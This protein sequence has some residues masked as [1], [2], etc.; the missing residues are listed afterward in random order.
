MEGFDVYEDAK[1]RAAEIAEIRVRE[2]IDKEGASQNVD[3]AIDYKEDF[4]SIGG[5]RPSVFVMTE[6]TA[7]VES[8]MQFIDMLKPVES[9]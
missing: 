5:G 3:I 4:W 9:R 2:I 8:Q 7:R 6:V 1:K